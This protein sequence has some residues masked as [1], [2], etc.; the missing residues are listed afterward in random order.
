MTIST[1]P[2]LRTDTETR[3]IVRGIL[4]DVDKYEKVDIIASMLNLDICQERVYQ[5]ISEIYY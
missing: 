3:K 1:Y 4:K 2:Y 5:L